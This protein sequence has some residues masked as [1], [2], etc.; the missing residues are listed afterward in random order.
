MKTTE[1][2]VVKILYVHPYN[3]YTGSTKVIADKLKS[4]YEDLS[5]V[6]VVT[7]TSQEGFLSGLGINLINVPIIKYNERAVPLI[8]QIVWIIVGF[9]KVLYYAGKFDYVYINTILPGF[10]AIAARLRGKKVIYHIHEK[11]TKHNY[12]SLFGEFVLKHIKAHHI[13]VSKYLQAQ[14]PDI[15][16]D[17]DEII[18]NKLGKD[19][20]ERVEVVPY[21]KHK[22]NRLIMLASL[23]KFKG[24][25]IFVELA[26]LLPSYYFT[27]IIS[28]TKEKIDAYFNNIKLSNLRILSRQNNI[29]P[30][31]KESDI[32]LNLSN[33]H[34]WVETFG[35]TILE[36]MMYGLPAIVPNVG[37]P[38]EIIE[39][40]VNGYCIDVADV[41][42]V[43]DTITR[44]CGEEEYSKL[45]TNA[46]LLSKKYIQL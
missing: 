4:E 19:F 33:P 28:D 21:E 42:S 16:S 8:S 39:N 24:I 18:Y 2:K 29:H 5:T 22:R 35:M 34:L 26:R 6:T 27:L 38:T 11:W 36:G 15:Y 37:G 12:K 46:L 45:Y 44:C 30:F 10:A 32:L 43:V 41:K 9:I 3:N 13:F 1:G 25:D 20:C 14:Y 23:N 7:D 17:Y 31:L 40:G